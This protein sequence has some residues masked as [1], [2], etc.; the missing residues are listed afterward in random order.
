VLFVWVC[1]CVRL[2]F[3]WVGG[4]VG[5]LVLFMWVCGLVCVRTHVH[6]CARARARVCA[7]P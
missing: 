7:K 3:V 5:V 6:M 4:W 1:G 2:L